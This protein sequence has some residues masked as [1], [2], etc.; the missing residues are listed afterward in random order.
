MP[1]TIAIGK[2]IAIGMIMRKRVTHNFHHGQLSRVLSP[3]CKP[4][5]PNIFHGAKWNSVYLFFFFFWNSKNKWRK[6]W[7]IIVNYIFDMI[8]IET[9][10]CLQ[11]Q[12]HWYLHRL[13]YR[14]EFMSNIKNNYIYCFT[15]RETFFLLPASHVVASAIFK[16][17]KKQNNE[18]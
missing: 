6:M 2:K 14:V 1:K 15:F 5:H 10:L 17:K 8:W 7:M 18:C 13:K 4:G 16:M 9:N 3:S 11:I 12:H